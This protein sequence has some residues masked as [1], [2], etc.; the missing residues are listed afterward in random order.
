MSALKLHTLKQKLWAIVAASFV[1]RVIAFFALPET[2]STLAPDEGTYGLVTS[3]VANEALQEQ[4]Y[5]YQNLY[6]TGRTLLL[7]SSFLAELGMDGLASTRLVSSAYGLSSLILLVLILIQIHSHPTLDP[8]K[9]IISDKVIVLLVFTYAFLP[10]HFIWSTLGL[11][12]STNEFW[13][14]LV[15]LLTYYFYK[16]TNRRI[17]FSFVTLTLVIVLVFSSRPQVG[18]L[19]CVSLLMF[20]LT[21]LKNPRTYLFV[22]TVLVGMMGGN[23]LTTPTIYFSESTFIATEVF[24]PTPTKDSTPTP[25]KD[26]T[27][28]PTKDSTPTPTKDSTPTPTKDS[29]PTPTKD[30]NPTSEEEITISKLCNFG[31]QKLESKS[32]KFV[33]EKVKTTTPIQETEIPRVGIVESVSNLSEGQ[34]AR[35]FGAASRIPTLYCPFIESNKLSSYACI[36]WRAPYASFTFLFRPLPILDTTSISSTLASIENLVWIIGIGSI[37]YLLVI[38]RRYVF[39][40]EALPSMIF[41]VLYVVGAGSYAGNMGTAFRHK[42]LILWIVL[43]LFFIA[44][45]RNQNQGNKPQESNSQESAV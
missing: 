31:G 20:C 38:K 26:S 43:L 22:P 44:F 16:E 25:T 8:T 2:P 30:S 10:S 27:P 21:Q 35:Q 14:I 3:W 33:C 37:L 7:P 4:I 36:A 24:P 34:K 13:L 1:A 29:T 15:F 12:E 45:W 11:R 19:V 40:T 23:F 32:R 39:K 9:H 42:S 18:L 5:F 41:L 17:L 28:T 6:F